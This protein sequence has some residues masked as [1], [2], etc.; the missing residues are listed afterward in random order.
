LLGRQPGEYPTAPPKRPAA[1]A[2][3]ANLEA[4]PT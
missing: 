2:G 4:A 3:T 1:P